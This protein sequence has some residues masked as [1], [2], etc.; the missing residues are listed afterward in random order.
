[1]QNIYIYK[2]LFQGNLFSLRNER[3]CAGIHMRRGI[4]FDCIPTGLEA[5]LET[6]ACILCWPECDFTFHSV[7][8]LTEGER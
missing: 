5:K 7:S 6:F 8:I 3:S 1:M 2:V 4:Y